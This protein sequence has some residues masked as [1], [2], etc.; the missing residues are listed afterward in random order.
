[1]EISSGWREL[2]NL[3]NDRFA[4]PERTSEHEFEREFASS[5]IELVADIPNKIGMLD[6]EGGA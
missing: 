3:S 1:M 5:N 2:F 4:D 6:G